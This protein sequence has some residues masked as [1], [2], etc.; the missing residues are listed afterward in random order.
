MPTLPPRVARVRAA[1]VWGAQGNNVCPTNSA[2]IRDKRTCEDAAGTRG[3]TF[4]GDGTHPTYPSGCYYYSPF[5]GSSGVYLNFHA[6]GAESSDSTPLC[7]GAH[8]SAGCLR[9]MPEPRPRWVVG[10]ACGVACRGAVRRAC[11][12]MGAPVGISTGCAPWLAATQDSTLQHR[13]ARCNTGQH[14]ATQGSTLQHRTARCNTARR[15]ATQGSTLQHSA[16]RCNTGQHVAAQHDVLQHR[17]TC[18]DAAVPRRAAC[19]CCSEHL[20]LGLQRQSH[21]HRVGRHVPE[22][23]ADAQLPVVH[24]GPSCSAH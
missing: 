23:V 6:T 7:K 8:P 24:R 22:C 11:C 12:A 14:V 18:R 4:M 2:K 17:A 21:L 5:F 10:R 15:A 13:A 1:Y 19:R 9:R 3:E 16:A 20:V